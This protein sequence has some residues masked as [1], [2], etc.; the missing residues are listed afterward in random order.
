[1]KNKIKL[2]LYDL[3]KLALLGAGS[4]GEVYL[5]QDTETKKKLA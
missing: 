5:V 1:M 3:Q 2:S 4:S